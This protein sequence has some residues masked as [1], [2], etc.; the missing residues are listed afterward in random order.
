MGVKLCRFEVKAE[1]GQI[2]SGMVF[3]GKVYETDGANAVA[4]HEA[5]SVR[6]LSP[7]PLAPSLRIVHNDFQ[8]LPGPDRE[9]PVFFY[10][11]P[12]CI[13]GASQTMN[14]PTYLR[15]VAFLPMLAAVIVTPGYRV[16]IDLADDLIL[17]LTLFGMLTAPPQTSGAAGW[18]ALVGRSV[19]I[20]SALGP[21]I[22]TPD[23]LDD[24]LVDQQ[25]GRQYG[26]NTVIRVNGVEK[27][28]GDL[29]HLPWTFAEVISAASQSCPVREGDVFV[30]GPIVESS[31]AI[32]AEPGDEL[33]IS[34]ENL[35]TLSLKL[36][37]ET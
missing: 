27:S 26:L 1:P 3:A 24:F 11:N 18:S 36:S 7:V 10:G 33:Q 20:G 14:I 13:V 30:M 19:D 15:S 25:F 37:D 22:T 8:P 28:R 35:G 2:R 31:E 12:T 34:A 5:E 29:Q 21:V 32:I 16:D 17:G 23:E 4:V 9:E 6:P